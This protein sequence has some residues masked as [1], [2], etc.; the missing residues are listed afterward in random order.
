M[1]PFLI[2]GALI[3]GAVVVSA[4]WK[5]IKSFIQASI[6]RIKTHLI[7]S[8]I[9]GFKTYLDTGNATYATAKALQKFFSKNERGN[10]QE[11]IVTREIP[12][13]EIPEDIRRKADRSNSS[14]IDI[15]DEVQTELH[16][17]V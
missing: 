1:I 6:E 16:L 8:M 9:V 4:F 5:E 12:A 15:T 3:A 13:S 11:T 10:W 17:E 2:A 14:V 7:P